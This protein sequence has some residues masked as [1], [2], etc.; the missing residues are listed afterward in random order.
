[1]QANQNK[2]IL[3]LAVNCPEAHIAY[4]YLE[5]H[6]TIAKVILENKI[7]SATLIKNRIRKLGC[8]KVFGQL[9]FQICI[10][11]LLIKISRRRIREITAGI[12]TINDLIPYSAIVKIKSVNDSST[13]ELIKSIPHDVIYILGTR[14]ISKKILD[15]LNTPIINMHAGITPKYRGVHGAYWAL[16]NKEPQLC[17]VTIHKVNKGIDTGEVINQ[18]IIT[19]GSKDNFA[20]YSYLQLATGLQLLKTELMHYFATKEWSKQKPLTLESKLWYHP[21]LFEY[22]F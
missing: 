15:S 11:K 6:F 20:T 7:S 2:R 5:Q 1:L 17:G 13:I 16:K 9:L 10:Q 22:L 21:T 8:F 19:P 18:A 14:I 4:N 3:I 12:T